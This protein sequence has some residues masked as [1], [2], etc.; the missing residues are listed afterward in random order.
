MKKK[1][2]KF[3]R[4]EIL[5]Q[6]GTLHYSLLYNEN[7]AI[8]VSELFEPPYKPTPLH[9][10]LFVLLNIIYLVCFKAHLT[11]HC[12]FQKIALFTKLID[13]SESTATSTTSIG[14][15]IMTQLR[16]KNPAE[17]MLGFTLIKYTVNKM[18]GKHVG[19]TI[20]GYKLSCEEQV[21]HVSR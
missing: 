17:L 20:S 2:G 7:S 3:E 19:R 11:T 18:S 4:R 10:Y 1:S 13:Q 9:T 15:P 16:M 12:N 8:H 21:L 14:K 6:F 5:P